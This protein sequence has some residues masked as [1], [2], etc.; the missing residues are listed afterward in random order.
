MKRSHSSPPHL[1]RVGLLAGSVMAAA[2]PASAVTLVPA[3]TPGGAH[4]TP[5]DIRSPTPGTFDVLQPNVNQ[6]VNYILGEYDGEPGLEDR[7]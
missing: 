3:Y 1:F 7:Q 6:F 5:I 4:Q 2:G